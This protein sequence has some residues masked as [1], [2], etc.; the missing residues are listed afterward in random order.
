MSPAHLSPVVLKHHEAGFRVSS[1]GAGGG[2]V[3]A[4]PA[5]RTPRVQPA[6]PA[7]TE[8][9]ERQVSKTRGVVVKRSECRSN[10]RQK[11]IKSE[12]KEKM[13]WAGGGGRKGEGKYIQTERRRGRRSA[14]NALSLPVSVRL[15]EARCCFR[16]SVT[17]SSL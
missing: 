3:P 17:L 11:E 12:E 6:Q 13:M 7:H 4:G 15:E 9:S 14:A 5:P 10:R 2:G 16:I 8:P 1:A